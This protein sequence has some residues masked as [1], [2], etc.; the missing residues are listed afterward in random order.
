MSD[1]DE[2]RYFASDADTYERVRLSLDRALGYPDAR[3]STS[4]SPLQFATR[5]AD[6]RVLLA[7]RQEFCAITAVARVLPSLLASGAAVE[8]TREEYDAAMPK[9]AP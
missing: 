7:T 3:A 6:G 8:I 9:G 4:F 1:M 5:A 2:N